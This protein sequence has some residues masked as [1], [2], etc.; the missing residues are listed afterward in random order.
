MAGLFWIH[1]YLCYRRHK[2][3]NCYRETRH[4]LRIWIRP[5]RL[6]TRSQ[7]FACSTTLTSSSTPPWAPSTSPAWSWS[8]CTP[9]YSRWS[10]ETLLE[11]FY[12]N[13]TISDSACPGSAEQVPLRLV[14]GVSAL[15]HGHPARSAVPQGDAQIHSLTRN[16]DISAKCNP[17][18]VSIIINR[19]YFIHASICLDRTIGI[20]LKFFYSF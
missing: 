17:A 13:I 2:C 10:Q 8:C 6:R 11:S 16:L 7:S 4:C 3:K 1:E 18:N 14:P 9:G 12:I 15:C 20:L 19:Q 5:G